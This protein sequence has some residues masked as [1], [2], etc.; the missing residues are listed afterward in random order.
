MIISPKRILWP[1]DFSPLS[2]HAAKYARGF[3]DVFKAELHVLHVITPPVTPDLNVMLPAE[4]PAAFSSEEL[5]TMGREFLQRTIREEFGDEK[6]I[7]YKTLLGTPWN[8]ICEYAEKNEIDLIIIGTHGR[9]GLT[10][11]LMGSTAERVVQ[12]ASCPVLVVKH[13][14]REFLVGE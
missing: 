10:R 14:E 8:G 2:R 4:P 1:T 12:H 5:H 6:G 9:T 11:A 7:L 13:R 3:R